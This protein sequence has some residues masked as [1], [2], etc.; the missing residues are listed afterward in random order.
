MPCA[1]VRKTNIRRLGEPPA[2]DYR[3][4]INHIIDSIRESQ[5]GIKIKYQSMDDAEWQAASITR[6]FGSADVHPYECIFC[7]GYHP[8]RPLKPHQKFY[9]RVLCLE[10]L[11]LYDFSAAQI[12]EIS[13]TRRK[14]KFKARGGYNQSWNVQMD[15]FAS[16]TD[17]GC[18][19]HADF[20]EWNTWLTN[21]SAN[22]KIGENDQ[23]NRRD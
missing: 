7:S 22:R 6:R 1:A 15:V 3:D 20:F 5:C 12:S 14:R 21:P 13:A 10:N 16:M 23:H 9:E 18:P 11:L 2:E 17:D 19:N 8:G 4:R